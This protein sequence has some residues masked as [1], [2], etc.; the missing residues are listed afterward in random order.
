MRYQE[1]GE[2]HLDFHGATATTINYVVKHFGHDALR[3]LMAQMAK[4]VYRDIYTQLQ[5]GNADALA[6]HWQYF[7]EREKGDFQITRH[8][9]GSIEL[10]VRECPAVRQLRAI[11]MD[12]SPDFCLQTKM[13]NDAWSEGS[14]FVITTEK[15]GE[16]SC[17][18]TIMVKEQKS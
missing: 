10:L 11:G 5:A 17:R 4:Q 8:G 13:I 16:A 1:T 9:D 15:T 2:L 3:P 18:Q 7:F 12:V 14:P 6:E